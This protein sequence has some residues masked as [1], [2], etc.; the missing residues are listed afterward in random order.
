MDQ[1]QQAQEIAGDVSDFDPTSTVVE[2]DDS[3]V[4]EPPAHG[5][6]YLD[7]SKNEHKEAKPEEVDELERDSER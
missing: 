5:D 4:A 2:G 1:E 7:V 3:I 6:N